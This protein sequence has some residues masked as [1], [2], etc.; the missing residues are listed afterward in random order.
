[1]EVYP[2]DTGYFKLDGG[3]MFGVVPKTIWNKVYPAD[4]N[5]L[6]TWAMR[7]LLI[8]EG[9]KKILIDTGLGDKQSDKFFSYYQPHGEATLLSSLR[10]YGCEP[11][12]ITDVVLTHLHFDHCGGAVRRNENKSGYLPVF[13]KANYWTHSQH[14]AH[15]LSPNPREKASFLTE[16]IQPLLDAG[17]IYFVDKQAPVFQSLTFKVVN[18]HTESML[19]PIIDYKGRMLIYGADLFPSSIHLPPN[20]VMG[21]DIRPLDTMKE[22]S[23]MLGF[24]HEHNAIIVFEHDAIHEACSLKKEESGRITVD[25]TLHLSEI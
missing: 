22:R 13:P 20:Y 15:A 21:Y 8:I 9:N 14:L 11:H 19:I 25:E 7:C 3:A 4:E 17:Q 23:E 6:C 10:K 16:N 18:G 24:A 2:I 1:M 12:D 5:N